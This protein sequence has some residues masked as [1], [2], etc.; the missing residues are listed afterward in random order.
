MPLGKDNGDGVLG[1]GTGGVLFPC[2]GA[3]VGAGDGAGVGA[4]ALG[5][6]VGAAVLFFVAE[7]AGVDGRRGAVGAAVVLCNVGDELRECTVRATITPPTTTTAAHT[8][9]AIAGESPLSCE[10]H[11]HA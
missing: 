6:C 1:G 11:P 7:G 2:V 3:G 8:A 9:T 4:V 5:G 10:P